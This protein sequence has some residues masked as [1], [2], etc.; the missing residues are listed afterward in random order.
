[1]ARYVVTVRTSKPP[2]E[3][4][5]YMA[6]M[7][8]FVEWDPGV[9]SAVAAP[10][11]DGD[12]PRMVDVTVKGVRP[13]TLRYKV[14]EFEPPHRMV[15][16][17]STSLLTSLDVITVEPTEDGCD[18]TYDAELTLNGIGSLFGFAL[19]PLFNRIGDKAAAGL[20]EVL[21]GRRVATPAAS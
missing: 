7:T 8:N 10:G 17:A 3:A 13:T 9:I 21:D 16:R 2:D 15:A 12:P 6:D 18:V 14:E 1:M 19:Q 11:E 5:A 20:I 4:F